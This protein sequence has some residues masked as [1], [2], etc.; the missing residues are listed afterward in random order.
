VVAASAAG[1]L[2]I[3]RDAAVE[4]GVPTQRV[5]DAMRALPDADGIGPLFADAFPAFAVTFGTY[6]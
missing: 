4:A 6:C 2:F 5:V 3:D 1:G